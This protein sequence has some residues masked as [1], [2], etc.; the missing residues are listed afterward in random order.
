MAIVKPNNN[1][2]SAI[3]A[4]GLPTGTVLQ[5]VQAETGTTFSTTSTSFVDVTGLVKSITPSSASNKVL[6]LIHF[7][8]GA[9]NSNSNRVQL[10]RGSTAISLGNSSNNLSNVYTAHGGTSQGFGDYSLSYID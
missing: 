9:D 10:R 1:T 8:Y 7:R 5:V 4:A 2:L 3:T 6:V